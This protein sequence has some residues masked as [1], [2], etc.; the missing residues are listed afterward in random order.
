MKA[1]PA[2]DDQRQKRRRELGIRDIVGGD[3]PPD[4]VDRDERYAQ[5]QRQTF[6]EIDADEQR[7]DEARGVRDGDGVDL[8]FADPRLAHRAVG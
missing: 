6:C 7:A 1:V 8:S 3:V 4:M 5:R 2:G